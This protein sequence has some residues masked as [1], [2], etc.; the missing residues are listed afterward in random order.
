MIYTFGQDKASLNGVVFD[1]LV[2]Y[3]EDMILNFE[4]YVPHSDLEN[5]AMPRDP[6]PSQPVQPAARLYYLDWLRVIAIL[7]VFLFH[8]V[9]PFDLT[10]WHIKNAEQSLAI[11][12]FIAFMFPWGMP[13]FFL[14]AGAG[15]WF[16]LR[17]RSA[18]E[19][20]RERF[21]RLLLPFIGGA[22]LLM[23][24]M[25]YFEWSHK[26]QTGLFHM[27]YWGFL[28]DRNVGFTPAWFGALGYHLW[29]LG[30][31]FS[32]S[33]LALP[34]CYWLKGS[35]GQAWVARLA[36]FCQHRGGIL[37]FILPLTLIRVALHPFFPQE[38]SWADF[39]VQMAF[40][41]SGFILFSN[42]GFLRAI[43]RDWW[44]ALVLGIAAA[45]AGMG[46]AL[47][48][49]TLDLQTAPHTL[50]DFLFWGLV[51]ID[52]WCW[53][54]FFVYIG[55]RFLDYSNRWLAYGQEAILPFFVFH[56]PVIIILAFY[57]VQWQAS[58]P[59]KLLFVVLG[60]FVVSLGIYELAVRRILPLRLVF[61]MKT[62][63][64]VSKGEAS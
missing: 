27:S 3:A 38:H 9:H 59:V 39:F 4:I 31:L 5:P 55:M 60:S 33:L 1:Q 25:L 50:R 6:L 16:A 54:I 11:T 52:S 19:F 62:N 29:F 43:K 48:S 34:I 64:L 17:R 20:A 23:P 41:L 7:G 13:F 56:Q 36:N 21:N 28:L 15:S 42:Q 8:A 24:V 63:R 51:S 61:G 57:A 14:L 12:V 45:A 18:Q 53:T 30:F 2:R 40:Y 49:G 32:F 47:S 58:L 10:A 37:I 26:T 22:I 46:M 35:A 44:I